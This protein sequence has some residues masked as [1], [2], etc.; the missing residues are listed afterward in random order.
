MKQYTHAGITYNVAPHRLDEFLEKHPGAIEVSEPGKKTGSADAGLLTVE[1]NSTELKLDDG[2]SGYKH[3]SKETWEK[4]KSRGWT[5]GWE[6]N[7]EAELKD[8]YGKDFKIEQ[9]WPG[10]DAIKLTSVN[11]GGPSKTFSW[12]RDLANHKGL[13]NWIEA[14]KPKE[15]NKTEHE[16]FKS[17]GLTPEE[18][19]R[20]QVG[21]ET[22]SYM[23]Q[24]VDIPVYEKAGPVK[25][26]KA[27]AEASA[28]YRRILRDVANKSEKNLLKNWQE[29]LG[30]EYWSNVAP[31]GDKVRK[32]LEDKG[33]VFE[34]DK[35]WAKFAGL[36]GEQHGVGLLG[37]ILADE[38][39][40]EQNKTLAINHKNSKDLLPKTKEQIEK[41]IVEG[42]SPNEK[43]KLNLEKQKQEARNTIDRLKEKKS[44][45]E[46]EKQ[47]HNLTLSIG[48]YNAEIKKLGE[49]IGGEEGDKI[50]SQAF[51]DET[52]KWR[53]EQTEK[54]KKQSQSYLNAAYRNVKTNNPELSD[55]D[56]WEKVYDAKALH[57][58]KLWGE[59]QT[60][61][62]DISLEAY[63]PDV[64]R[65]GMWE[66][67]LYHMLTEK[68]HIPE[69][70]KTGDIA[71]VPIK[72]LF[73]A[74]IYS[75][76]FRGFIDQAFTSTA[77]D[78]EN[79]DKLRQYETSIYRTKG[80]LAAM[81]ELVFLNNS[82][83]AY[84]RTGHGLNVG[85]KGMITHFTDVPEY[86]A[87][88]IVGKGRGHTDDYILGKMQEVADE[89]NTAVR[90][91]AFVDESG[92]KIKVEPHIWTKEDAEAF[93]KTLVEDI[94]EGVGHFAPMLVELGAYSAV[95]GQIFNIPKV[96]AAMNAMR[97]G[98]AFSKLGYHG[99]MAMTEEVKM[100][101]ADFTPGTG[102]AFYAGGV[103]T[104][105]WYLPG[106]NFKKRF[107]W[108]DPVYQKVLKAGPVGAASSQLANVAALKYQ[109]LMGNKDFK[110]NFDAMYGDLDQTAKDVLVEAV[111]FSIVGAT[112]LK[113]VRME[114]GKLKRGVDL[115]RTQDKEKAVK[116]IV[117]K[118]A[119]MIK[120]AG[121][122]EPISKKEAWKMLDRGFAGE[123]LMFYEGKPPGY[124]K[125]TLKNQEKYDALEKGKQTIEAQRRV[126]DMAFD[127]DPR[128]EKFQENS[129]RMIFD[130][131]IRG[132]Q[133][134][135]PEYKGF[136]V[137][138]T[139]NPRE[140]KNKGAVA[141]YIPSKSGGKDLLL[142]NKDNYTPG[143][144][145]HE[146]VHAAVSAKIKQNDIYGKN[147]VKQM[148]K[149]FKQFDFKTLEG[150]PLGDAINQ[151]Y[152]RQTV[153]EGKAGDL[154]TKEGK[155][156]KNEEFLAY[157]VELLADPKVYRQHVAKNFFLE[158]KN[159]F[160]SMYEETFGIR[161]KIR[162]AGEFVNML[163]RLAQ[164]AR[165]GLSIETKVS[166]MAELDK[167]DFK[168]LQYEKNRNEKAEKI[169][170][171]S[172]KE[173]KETA[174]RDQKE[175]TPEKK[176]RL[177]QESDK[178]LD[179]VLGEYYNIQGFNKMSKEQQAKEWGKLP[180][181]QKLV[182]GYMLADKWKSWVEMKADLN[183][184]DMGSLWTS[185]RNE[186]IEKITTGIE[187]QDNGLPY[188]VRSW[189]PEESKLT[190]YIYGNLTKR[191]GHTQRTIEGFGEQMVGMEKAEDVTTGAP[192]AVKIKTNKIDKN[193][194]IT[195]K[196]K[197][198]QVK[199]YKFEVD[200]KEKKLNKESIEN[201]DKANETSFIETKEGELTFMQATP[202]TEK[203]AIKEFDNFVGITP[204]MSKKDKVEIMNDFI[205][206]NKEIAYDMILEPYTKDF[207]KIRMYESSESAKSIFG[208]FMREIKSPEGK[209]QK[210]TYAEMPPTLP[211]KTR[212]SQPVKRE[213]MPANEK[214]L[215]EFVKLMTEGRD[216]TVLTTRHD[217]W[218]KHFAGNINS[219][220]IRNLRNNPEAVK[221]I[222]QT[223]QGKKNLAKLEM[224]ETL[225]KIKG[226]MD[227]AMASKLLS[228]AE[229]AFPKIERDRLTGVFV[230]HAM[231]NWDS[232][233]KKIH[234]FINSFKGN[235]YYF[236]DVKHA[237]AWAAIESTAKGGK[238]A[239]F[240]FEKDF[241]NYWD[242]FKGELPH[243]LKGKDI[244]GINTKAFASTD[245]GNTIV[246]VPRLEKYLKITEEF[247][248]YLPKEAKESLVFLDQ[249]LGLHYRVTQEGVKDFV[250]YDKEGDVK[251]FI[252]DQKGKPLTNEYVT[253]I[254]ERV[255]KVLGKNT[256][257]GFKDIETMK[258]KSA[259]TQAAGQKKMMEA[260]GNFFKQLEVAE[261]Y[262]SELDNKNKKDIYFAVES[263]KEQFIKD[264][265]NAQ[266]AKD[267]IE[268]MYQIVRGNSN[269]R[270]GLRQTVPVEWMYMPDGK[271][272]GEKVKLEHM[273]SM[274]QQGAQ[275][276]HLIAAGK[277][278]ETGKDMTSDFIGIT[279]DK[280]LLDIVDQVG[281]TTNTTGLYRMATLD[282]MTLMD[283]RSVKDPSKNMYDAIMDK[284][285]KELFN[286]KIKEQLVR[287]KAVEKK[288]IEVLDG[289]MARASKNL[290]RA[291]REKA[292]KT[293]DK[294]IIEGS[295]KNKK[296][297]GGSFWDADDTLLRSKSGVIFKE[298]NPTGEPQPS[299]KVIFLAG[300]AGSGKSNVVKQLGL[301]KQGFKIV[302][303]DISLE[304]LKKNHGLPENM[305]DLTKEQASTLGKLT[306]EARR[307]AARKKMKFQGKGD[308]IVVDGTGGSAKAM[309]KQVAEFRDKG[310]D[311]QMLF[312]ETSLATAQAR[313]KARKERTLSE[314][315]VRRNHESVQANKS[316]FKKLFGENFA[317]VK[318]DKLKIGDAMPPELIAK[319]D[320]FTKG[321]KKG[322][323]TAEEFANEGSNI[324]ERGGKFDFSEFN[325]VVEGETGP[326]F[327]KALERAKKFGTKDQFIITARPPEAQK[328]LYEFFKSQ[329]LEIPL[330]NIHCL[331][332]STPEAKALKIAEK[333]GEG[334]NDIYFADDVL[335]NV[336]A[337]KNIMK[338]FD[339]KGE[340]QQA[341]ASK[342]LSA[343]INRR[344]EHSLGIDPKKKFTRAE[345]KVRG[346]DIKRRRMF[347]TDSAADLELLIEPLYG[348][349]KKGIENKKWLEEEFIKPFEIG[350]NNYNTARQTAKNDY[351][352]LRKQNKDVVK[353]LNK[354][355]EGTSFTNDQAMRV[356]LWNKAGYKIPDLAKTTEAKLVNHIKSDPKLVH[357]AET[358]G[359]ITKIEKGLKEPSAE[360]WGETI[361]GEVSN[362][363]RGV[364]RKQYLQN[365]IDAKNEIF[366]PENMNKMESKLG[367]NWR[368]NI[369]DMFDRMETGR[370]R[371]LTTD[372]GSAMMMN[373][374]N[375][376]VGTIMNFN[377][378]SAALQT[379]STINFLN[380]R[381]NNPIE[382]AKAM[383]NTK[384]FSKDFLKIM[385]S[386]MLKQRRDGLE[387][388]V[389]EAELA[390][391]A[392]NSKNP[393]NSMIAKTLKV[394]YLPTK[395]ADSFAI[396]F[397][398]A[399][400][401]RNRAKMYQKQGLSLKEAEAKAWTD[402][403]MLSE[404]TQQ[405]SRPDLLSRQQTSLVGRIVLP[406]ANTPMQMNRRGMKD[407]LDISKG[408]Y[409]DRV[410]MAEKMGR[411]SYYMGAQVALFAGLQSALFAMLLN[412]EDVADEKIATAKTYTL[413]TISDSFLRGMGVQGAVVSG[414]K[415]AVQ[416]YYKQS[417]KGY[418]ADYSEVG[419][420]LLNISP[421][422]GSKYGKLDQAG[423]IWKWNRK[424][425]EKEGFR[426]EL[427]SPSLE[428]S[429]LAVEA[430]TNI[431]V[432]R[433]YKK[434]NNIKHS[435]NDDYEAWQRFHMVGGYTPHSVGIESEKKKKK[436]KS[437]IP[438]YIPW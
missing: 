230:D 380:M 367:T 44:T 137:R 15:A 188:L 273:K 298:P 243:G 94:G 31:I 382:A 300:G 247:A 414:F 215:D 14:N 269:L 32:K 428:A 7:I 307:I 35:E 210:F 221:R 177:F 368:E 57:L 286:G 105:N 410:E 405:S 258:F 120:D 67:K 81:H 279:S 333:I 213:K 353:K 311:V 220:S 251:G 373:Y 409:K 69:D 238:S 391:A 152:G 146:V 211:K 347:M 392:A 376:S 365:W 290:T 12:G 141:E 355:V 60:G 330:E 151:H 83:E 294:A 226:P 362:V 338:Q 135:V 350:I 401:Y 85:L 162:N 302:N 241:A 363:G 133:A 195:E 423:N 98:N 61:T 128:N 111:V 26:E 178:K 256:Y 310:Y 383:G 38:A 132:I 39:V 421:P 185:K 274:I 324:L 18:Y 320:A 77:I 341:M 351:M 270:M 359:R 190:S 271:I 386:D 304:W 21:S 214:I 266:E 222:S 106:L 349:G 68:G 209:T 160:Q 252:L 76:N 25:T 254:R 29:D 312:V 265:K 33:I 88:K 37:S 242:N 204:E 282:P 24:V 283:F 147:F 237:S 187:K 145:I 65:V 117:A 163:G 408:R 70:Y 250:K 280:R 78:D 169:S 139:T 148:D 11:P 66:H 131:A 246:D 174:T 404:R 261:K 412:D 158:A 407:I 108:A 422:I 127:L 331:G 192:T 342:D 434:S 48:G 218:K 129:Q 429:T 306:W 216:N 107:K 116:S 130:P 183:Y 321:Y 419:E 319:M 74:K 1:P 71:K 90:K 212:A 124:E 122:G 80:E 394:G 303:Q 229:K 3:I 322:R 293:I 109:D 406:F 182:V 172:S 435:L 224:E 157:M 30:K 374:L 79:L 431:P 358:F 186:F 143:K 335:V 240:K 316:E 400:Y 84:E 47:I 288:Q 142:F 96:A 387:I 140:F 356:Y 86:E 206:N 235:E 267:R 181:D 82:P 159:E 396:S 112:H 53:H 388:N 176:E 296:K 232:R 389:T 16:I 51:V 361:A 168:I 22:Q 420:K 326:L 268:W 175:F 193:L 295:K 348:K 318:T 325:K 199:D 46:I 156:I 345:G 377:T 317:E 55:R 59:G 103:A 257:E 437:K 228:S 167:M 249:V 339:V 28:E 352:G 20:L 113:G 119:Q 54:Y 198:V 264:A 43:K 277:F 201:I 170:G 101:A 364:S 189:K 432:N 413:G 203:A 411:I 114:N 248:K 301:E 95:G 4:P 50:K 42:Y 104:R 354:P 369:E 118:Q 416:E 366:S 87:D 196:S 308:G 255:L 52:S 278:K 93:E 219:Q 40:N 375:G 73:D 223:E 334:Y 134:V 180:A 276:G 56:A 379:I 398:G 357:Y 225:M 370:T 433:A 194:D 144:T 184:S 287:E 36:G 297:K 200:G 2:S 97:G 281:G 166:A 402:F 161:P 427:G 418:G 315:I 262:F 305:K 337:V 393:I 346:K 149:A 289:A 415:N 395:L 72:D 9:V 309:Q 328:A 179:K 253:N 58:Q 340:V 155:K 19:P 208:R 126:E 234:D 327:G 284:A 49:S 424:E 275:A 102:A 329:G 372:R 336:Q 360:W 425:I 438:K 153:K 164:D 99:I 231:G 27:I 17:S 227:G 436:K 285:N 6:G 417:G 385:N 381:E 123:G 45:P 245:K 110:T 239:E 259:S 314:S 202:K 332:N 34:S 10:I 165:R 115:M 92:E 138:F 403:Q 343:N 233:N 323:L 173:L 191:F 121:K 91:E 100:A 136:D 272:V 397:G 217:L 13:I 292:I 263:A 384:Q 41:F 378:R 150:T 344:M 154:R 371:S 75:G 236:K 260:G 426:F 299:R 205:K 63:D 171:Y 313:N 399:T 244:K 64:G 430:I 197:G 8:V 291:E 62:V 390:S 5:K 125:L 89:Y 23:G 207:K